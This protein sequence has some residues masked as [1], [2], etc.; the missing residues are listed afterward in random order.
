MGV[1]GV[2]WMGL[3]FGSSLGQRFV[4]TLTMIEAEK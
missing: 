3:P 4:A 1:Q 2:K